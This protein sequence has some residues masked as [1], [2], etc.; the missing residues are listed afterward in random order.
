ML[1]SPSRLDTPA[2]PLSS[3]IECR[4]FDEKQPSKSL[5][6]LL[7][8]EVVEIALQR[9]LH[10]GVELIEWRA[11]LY[12][13]MKVPIMVK[14]YAYVVQDDDLEG[15]SDILTSLGLPVLQPSKLLLRAEGDLQAKGRFHQVTRTTKPAWVQH[16]VL[17]PQSFVSINPAELIEPPQPDSSGLRSVS[18]PR[19]SSVYAS[20]LRLMLK[21]PRCC[22]TRTALG[23]DLSELIGYHLCDI[24]Q[25]YVDADDESWEEARVNER[26]EEAVQT[27]RRWG[28]DGEWREGEEWMGDALA[29]FVRGSGDIDFLPWQS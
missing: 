27:V 14:N 29:A 1:H 24:I 5:L 19:P 18:I 8:E 13:R 23:S 25:G 2:Y 28:W 15:A 9:L 6:D 4:T 20:I 26:I 7:P 21:Y 12:R 11:P 16:L 10:A 17:Y 22:S 3:P